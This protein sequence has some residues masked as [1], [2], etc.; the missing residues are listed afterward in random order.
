MLSCIWTL[1][2][3]RGLP[4]EKHIPT[5]GPLRKCSPLPGKLFLKTHL[6]LSLLVYSHLCSH[7]TSSDTHITLCA[8]V[9]SSFSS[10][11]LAT[12]WHAMHWF[13]SPLPVFPTKMQA[14]RGQG[15]SCSWLCPKQLLQ[16]QPV[17]CVHQTLNLHNNLLGLSLLLSPFYMGEN[18][19]WDILKNLPKV[20]VSKW[21]G[22]H[23]N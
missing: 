18:G 16:G 14:P 9:P 10:S 4:G 5:Q 7:I 1:T 23:S 20:R 8:L 13:I 12:S 2:S 21:R 6:W 22:I 15:L 17:L 3:A 11:V 19:G